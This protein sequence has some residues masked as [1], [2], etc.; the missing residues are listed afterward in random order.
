MLGVGQFL[1]QA[2]HFR[3]PFVAHLQRLESQFQALRFQFS[4]RLA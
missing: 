4:Y 3:L 2:F 1:P